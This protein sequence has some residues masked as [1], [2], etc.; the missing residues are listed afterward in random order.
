MVTTI[1]GDNGTYLNIDMWYGNEFVPGQYGADSFFNDNSAIYWGWIYDDAGKII[2]DYETDDSV[3]VQENFL[4]DWAGD[5][6]GADLRRDIRTIAE[7][8]NDLG[9]NVTACDS[10]NC[11]TEPKYT[12]NMVSA[13]TS[14]SSL[15]FENYGDVNF[16]DDGCVAAADPDRDGCYYVITCYPVEDVNSDHHYLIQDCYVDINDSWID[17]D[18]VGDYSGVHGFKTKEEEAWFA[19]DCVHYYGGQNFGA[20]VPPMGL[21]NYDDVLYTAEGVEEYMSKYNL[22]SSIY[23]DGE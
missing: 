9:G 11:A 12:A 20:N 23:F 16:L 10:I 1:N 17:P 7:K 3:L 8:L 2:G 15:V 18:A 5:Q 4:I 14:N 6:R 21:D 22:P 13:S 19:V